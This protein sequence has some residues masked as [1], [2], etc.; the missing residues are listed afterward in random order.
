MC[1]IG[2]D[3]I[4]SGMDFLLTSFIICR[5]PFFFPKQLSE[6]IATPIF[7]EN[8]LASCI[9]GNGVNSINTLNKPI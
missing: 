2:T 7:G 1:C 9:D 6:I 4:S 8:N 5:L 3:N